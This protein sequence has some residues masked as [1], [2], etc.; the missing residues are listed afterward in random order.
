[1]FI[2]LKMLV[3]SFTFFLENANKNH[4]IIRL[5]FPPNRTLHSGAEREA[6]VE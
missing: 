3:N 6:V 5:F 2:T 4:Q 1:M